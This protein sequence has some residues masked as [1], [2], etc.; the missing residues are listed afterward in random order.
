MPH[1]S[2][3]A[4]FLNM[5]GGNKTAQSV[6]FKRFELLGRQIAGVFIRTKNLNGCTDQT[7][8]E[9]I[10]EGILKIFRY[11]QVSDKKLYLFASEVLTQN[12][13]RKVI[14]IEQSKAI[15]I[16]ELDAEISVDDNRSYHDVIADEQDNSF[17]PFSTL[18]E[19]IDSLSS[20]N[21]SYF[22]KAA[23]Y[24]LLYSAG[25]TLRELSNM[26]KRNMYQIRKAIKY[27]EDH[28]SDYNLELDLK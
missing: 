5:V 25:Y 6:L 13:Q 22:K 9:D 10:H 28:I 15:S 21:D 24:Y 14:A 17:I 27:V 12:I 4:L 7:F 23:K 26:T 20:V 8:I 19:A 2:D 1:L 18:D 3:E 11:Y 16:L